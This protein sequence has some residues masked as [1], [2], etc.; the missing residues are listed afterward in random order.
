MYNQNF[1]FLT[2]FLGL[3]FQSLL[4]KLRNQNLPLAEIAPWHFAE[5]EQASFA[6]FREAN[7]R[8]L[9]IL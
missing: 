8:I 4:A 5:G 6:F 2:G 3:F 1:I 7:E 9:L